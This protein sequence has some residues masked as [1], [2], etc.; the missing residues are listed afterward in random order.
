MLMFVLFHIHVQYRDFLVG[1][2]LADVA[3]NMRAVIGFDAD[4]HLIDA[5]VVILPMHFDNPLGVRAL[6]VLQIGKFLRLLLWALSL[7]D[8]GQGAA[9]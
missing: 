3:Q 5:M 6:Q 9:G 4:V 8:C 2:H 1:K 7:D